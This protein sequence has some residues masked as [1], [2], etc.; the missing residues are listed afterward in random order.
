M[1]TS[2][3]PLSIWEQIAGD[4]VF[5]EFGFPTEA[6]I[7]ARQ[8]WAEVRHEFLEELVRATINP[9]RAIEDENALPLYAI[10]LAAEMRDSAFE[11]AMLDLL[12]LP[13]EQLD[14]LLGDSL[15]EDMGRCLASVHAGDGASLRTLATDQRAYIYARLA[16]IDAMRVRT[17]EGDVNADETTAFLFGLAQNLAVVFR[18]HPPLRDTPYDRIEDDE[19]FNVMVSALA[20]LGATQYWPAIEQWHRNGLIDPQMG[21][22][23]SIR[24]TI[25]ADAETRLA[26]MH[27]PRYIRDTVA[28]MSWWACFTE[29][30][31]DHEWSGRDD[32][33]QNRY[34][35]TLT[36]PFVREQPKVGRNDPCPC[37][38]GKKFKK[39]CGASL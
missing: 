7:E 6:V 32:D 24:F 39:C 18:D 19:L 16:A 26:R 36:L 37:K 29:E 12:R 27:K 14:S 17:I 3:T 11:P 13:F 33:S 31:F 10:F 4:L 34:G 2:A 25:F 35:D 38:S 8:H 30:S 1:N 15:T 5:I 20:D 23:D 9:A 21:D 28:E 22:I